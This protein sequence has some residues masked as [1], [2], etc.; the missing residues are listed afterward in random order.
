MML[1]NDNK[2]SKMSEI[3]IAEEYSMYLQRVLVLDIEQGAELSRGLSQQEFLSYD[4]F[5]DYYILALV[6]KN[7]YLD[8]LAQAMQHQQLIEN[9]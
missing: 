7:N 3:S 1:L 4:E 8:N 9:A 6:G 5:K 2:M